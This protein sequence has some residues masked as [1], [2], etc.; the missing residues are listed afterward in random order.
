MKELKTLR[1]VRSRLDAPFV[2]R[3]WHQFRG[4]EGYGPGGE[5]WCVISLL[6]LVAFFFVGWVTS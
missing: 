5:M 6:G 1:D 4:R 3:A 2:V